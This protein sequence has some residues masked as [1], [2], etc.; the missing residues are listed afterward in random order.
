MVNDNN[1]TDI[2]M[3]SL[4]T[5]FLI[6]AVTVAFGAGAVSPLSVYPA[7]PTVKVIV[8]SSNCA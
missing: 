6:G 3:N 7:G 4:R 8:S 2:T 5:T 1:Q